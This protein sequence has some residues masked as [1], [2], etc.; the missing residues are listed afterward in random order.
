[1]CICRPT[2]R[3]DQKLIYDAL[4]EKQKLKFKTRWDNLPPT[5]DPMVVR[6]EGDGIVEH[7]E[8]DGALEVV[9]R[10]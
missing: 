10:R 4:S 5:G 8:A 6:E 1:M 3:A 2:N 9:I 7:V